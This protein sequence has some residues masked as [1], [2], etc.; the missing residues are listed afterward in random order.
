MAPNQS[1]FFCSKVLGVGSPWAQ[2]RCGEEDI[3]VID[4][5]LGDGRLGE[6]IEDVEPVPPRPMIA[7]RFAR[8]FAVAAPIPARVVAIQGS[9]THAP[10]LRRRRLQAFHFSDRNRCDY[11]SCQIMRT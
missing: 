9:E 5:N 4:I 7:M 3:P 10:E 11:R 6:E 2:M 1:T 8:S